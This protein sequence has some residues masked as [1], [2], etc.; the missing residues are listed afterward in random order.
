MR[1][2][3]LKLYAKWMRACP[4][5]LYAKEG[6]GSSGVEQGTENPCVDSSNL[7]RGTRTTFN[8]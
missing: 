2:C 6:R 1:A 8:F 4:L 5:K 7:S 3:P